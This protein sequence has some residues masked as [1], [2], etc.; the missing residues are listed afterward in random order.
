MWTESDTTA[1]DNS[2]QLSDEKIETIKTLM[3]E[4]VL[5]NVPNWAKDLD[6]TDGVWRQKMKEQSSKSN[7]SNK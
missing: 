1:R 5:G 4:V 3:S 6:T 7:G 2:I